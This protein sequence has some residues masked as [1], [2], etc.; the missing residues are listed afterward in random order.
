MQLVRIHSGNEALLYMAD[1]VPTHAHVPPAWNMG[2]DLWPMTTI[3]EKGAILGE[4]ASN[5]WTL[6]F[7][8]DPEIEI[9]GV[10]MTERGAKIAG[11][12]MLTD[13]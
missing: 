10:E 12:R 13:L 9:A 7:E 4:A 2:Y 5:G 3:E 1:L 11:A 6:F 8:H